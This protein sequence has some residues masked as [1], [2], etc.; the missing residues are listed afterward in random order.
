MTF[1]A[2]SSLPCACIHTSSYSYDFASEYKDERLSQR[3]VL[4]NALYL[5]R[6]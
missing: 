3:S 5:L 4:S 2:L 6:V 1:R